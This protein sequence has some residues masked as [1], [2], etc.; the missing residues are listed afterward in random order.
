MQFMDNHTRGDKLNKYRA[1]VQLGADHSAY[2]DAIPS[3]GVAKNRLSHS[4][5]RH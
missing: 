5:N 3:N 4:P 1:T 2:T